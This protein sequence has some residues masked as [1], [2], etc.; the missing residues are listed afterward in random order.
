MFLF[1]QATGQPYE[2][3]AKMIFMELNDAW[4]EFENQG[5]KALFWN[6][7]SGSQLD[8]TRPDRT[9][10]GLTKQGLAWARLDRTEPTLGLWGHRA[11]ER[12]PLNHSL[13]PS[14]LSS[15]STVKEKDIFCLTFGCSE[16]FPHWLINSQLKT[17]WSFLNSLPTCTTAWVVLQTSGGRNGWQSHKEDKMGRKS[18]DARTLNITKLIIMTVICGW[19][20]LMTLSNKMLVNFGYGW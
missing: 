14:L 9:G 12:C 8:Q 6:P 11:S 4:S 19:K 1:L 20:D 3:Y 7:W 13:L 17:L 10:F 15:V 5:S 18:D 2:Q 16:K